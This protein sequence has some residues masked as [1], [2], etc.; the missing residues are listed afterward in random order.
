MGTRRYL[1]ISYSL[2]L[3]SSL[4][5]TRVNCHPSTYFKL[6][7]STLMMVSGRLGNCREIKNPTSVELCIV[8]DSDVMKES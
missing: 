8:T 3:A 6:F 1:K 2:F 7:L 5:F 4:S